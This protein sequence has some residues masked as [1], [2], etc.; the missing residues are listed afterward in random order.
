MKKTETDTIQLKNQTNQGSDNMKGWE[1]KKLGEV[2]EY[3]KAPNK[4][5]DL[6][7]VGLDHLNQEVLKA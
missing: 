7:Y 6:P 1:I 3:D 5:I 2:C 4:K